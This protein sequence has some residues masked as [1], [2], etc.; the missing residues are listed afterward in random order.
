[1]RHGSDPKEALGEPAVGGRV[2]ASLELNFGPAAPLEVGGAPARATPLTG[3]VLEYEHL[4]CTFNEKGEILSLIRKADGRRW[5]GDEQRGNWLSLYVDRP[6]DRDAWDVDRPY[7]EERVGTTEAVGLGTVWAGPAR[8]VPEFNFKVDSSKLR[9]RAVLT[10]DS[11]RIDFEIEIDWVEQPKMMRVGLETPL[12]RGCL[13]SSVNTASW[14]T[15]RTG[16]TATKRA[17]S[18]CPASDGRP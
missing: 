1:M 12:Q 14:I 3:L 7:R 13:R 10:A 9:Q 11:P 6:V 18:R 5:V 4:R 2:V 16:T 15:R 17:S 8:S